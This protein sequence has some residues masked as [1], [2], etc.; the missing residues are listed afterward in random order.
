[1]KKA[2]LPI[3]IAAVKARS[4][5]RA[6]SSLRHGDVTLKTYTLRKAECLECDQH[7]EK[8]RGIFCLACRCP[9]WFFS[10]LRTKWRILKIKCPLDKW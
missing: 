10:D 3:R 9:Q 2:W 1:M 6:I 5:L 4:L 8:E 7:I